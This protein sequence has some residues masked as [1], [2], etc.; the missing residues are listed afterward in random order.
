MLLAFAALPL[1]VR[2]VPNALPIGEAPPLDLR[3]LGFRRADDAAERG[4]LRPGAGAAQHGRPRRLF[5]PRGLALVGAG[6]EHLRSAL[7]IA[8][9]VLLISSGLLIR[10]LLRV[11]ATSAASRPRASVARCARRCRCR[12]TRPRRRIAFHAG[13]V[14]QVQ[15][16]GVEH[17]PRRLP[18][19]GDDRRYWTIEAEGHP[20][21]PGE[22]RTASMRYVTPG[23]SQTLGMT[24]RRR[25]RRE[26]HG[27]G[28]TLQVAVVAVVRRPLLAGRGHRPTLSLRP[29]RRR[30]DQQRAALPGPDDRRRRRRRQGARP[31][32]AQR[33]AG[34]PAAPP[35][36]EEDSMGWYT[37]QDLAVR[38]KGNALHDRSG[39]GIVARADPAQPTPTCARSRRS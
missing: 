1:V 15:A 8:E 16:L 28:G 12:S 14:E 25:T 18:V 33:A 10:A 9:V 7:V 17:R 6:R 35:A 3:I 19:D 32:A 5:P 27:H 39:A 21:Q 34:L 31:R 29:A 36:A 22:G 38:Y 37:P 2:L 11:Q 24:T 23:Y 30:R 4:L 26:Q 20:T 13:V